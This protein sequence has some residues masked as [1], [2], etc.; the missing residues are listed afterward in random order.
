MKASELVAQ[1][2]GLIA[3][4]GDL[5]VLSY[6][7]LEPATAYTAARALGVCEV[8]LEESSGLFRPWRDFSLDEPETQ[9]PT[10]AVLL[11]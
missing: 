2:Q 4:H 10:S 1:L 8:F 5:E 11:N 7:P 3:E 6:E 9:Q